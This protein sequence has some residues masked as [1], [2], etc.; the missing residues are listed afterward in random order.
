MQRWTPSSGLE[1]REWSLGTE[2]SLSPFRERQPAEG[3]ENPPAVEVRFDR[4][5]SEQR[6]SQRPDARPDQAEATPEAAP[7]QLDVRPGDW[8]ETG[9]FPAAVAQSAPLPRDTPS[10]GIS[11]KNLLPTTPT[12]AAQA[13]ALPSFPVATAPIESPD[14]LSF[15]GA[16]TLGT[17]LSA[18]GA[19]QT[20]I[21]A[22]H[23]PGPAPVQSAVGHAAPTLPPAPAS[24]TINS[25]AAALPTPEAPAE[26]MR[27]IS[28]T[29]V[30]IEALRLELNADGRQARLELQP[31]ELGRVAVQLELRAK[32]VRAVLRVESKHAL[33]ALQNQMPELRQ[34]FEARGLSVE[35]IELHFDPRNA[36]N[37]GRGQEQPFQPAPR[38]YSLRV[39][40][41]RAPL[42]APEPR[43]ASNSTLPQ[44]GSIDTF[45]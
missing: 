9:L 39:A 31:A 45:A 21:G 7:E 18:H 40:S 41:S 5:L 44:G 4:A 1:S 33:E 15:V 37:G 34:A 28:T 36:A 29:S 43:I 6:S 27:E 24:P 32:S 10:N 13:Q 8:T 11:L 3:R 25:S 19:D 38:R 2:R 23:S 26:G 42:T 30:Q 12:Q 22:N 20:A 35:H 17:G 14:T 16:A